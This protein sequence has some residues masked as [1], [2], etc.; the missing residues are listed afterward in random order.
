MLIYFSLCYSMYVFM[1]VCMYVCMQV[2][3]RKRD[4]TG[5]LGT[6]TQNEDKESVTWHH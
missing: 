1:Y 6:K 5:S 4:R 2:R 3:E